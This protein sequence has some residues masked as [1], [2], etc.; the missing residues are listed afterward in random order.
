M[1]V[2]VVARD[3]KSNKVSD[4]LIESASKLIMDPPTHLPYLFTCLNG[5]QNLHRIPLNVAFY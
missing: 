5:K 1:Y 2:W 4:Q 3:I